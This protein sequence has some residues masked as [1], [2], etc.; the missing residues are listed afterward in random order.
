MDKVVGVVEAELCGCSDDEG[1]A[2]GF[3]VRSDDEGEAVELCA[4]SDDE[5]EAVESC[6]WLDEVEVAELCASDAG[7]RFCVFCMPHPD[8]PR[9][10]LAVSRA[11]MVAA[12][13]FII[14]HLP[15]YNVKLSFAEISLLHCERLRK[16]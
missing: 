2:V 15:F 8:R 9:H 3:C 10:R 14:S 13:F 7:V 12:N 6:V 5:G 4:R 16:I 11:V 1:E